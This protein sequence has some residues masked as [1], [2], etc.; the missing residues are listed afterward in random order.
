MNNDL[1][2]KYEQHLE[3]LDRELV[4]VNQAG[5]FDSQIPPLVNALVFAQRKLP[6]LFPLA[7][8]PFQQQARPA[9]PELLFNCAEDAS[10]F[11]PLCTRSTWL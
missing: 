11:L 3:F 1:K 5:L 4:D 9:S 10:T 7:R 6:L 2:T 8:Q